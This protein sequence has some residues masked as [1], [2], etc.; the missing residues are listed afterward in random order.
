MIVSQNEVRARIDQ[1]QLN[2]EGYRRQLS[3]LELSGDRRERLERDVLLIGEEIATLEKIAQVGRV[4]PNRDRIEEIVRER[5]AVFKTPVRIAF[6]PSMLPRN[7]NGKILK[8]E[9]KALFD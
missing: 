3:R 4:E 9:L 8:H 1:L 7:A 5:L 6:L 2:Y